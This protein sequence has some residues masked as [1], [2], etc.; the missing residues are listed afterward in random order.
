MLGI[1]L[2]VVDRS[3]PGVDV[4][5]GLVLSGVFFLVTWAGNLES[6]GPG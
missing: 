6:A 4:V 1:T 2:G 5:S 3:K